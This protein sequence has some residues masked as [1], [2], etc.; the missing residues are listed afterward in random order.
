MCPEKVSVGVA[1][2]LFLSADEVCRLLAGPTA[3]ANRLLAGPAAA[4]TCRLMAGPTAAVVC[5][6]LAGPAA[7]TEP[8]IQP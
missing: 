4:V 7:V 5:R 1:C 8:D 3:V 2:N 6:L